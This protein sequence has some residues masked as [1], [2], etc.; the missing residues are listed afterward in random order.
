MRV[1]SA[2]EVRCSV[3]FRSVLFC[4]VRFCPVLFCCMHIEAV[5]C[6]RY[7]CLQCAVVCTHCQWYILHCQQPSVICGQCSDRSQCCQQNCSKGVAI[8]GSQIV[9]KKGTWP[10]NLSGRVVSGS[11]QMCTCRVKYGAEK[12]SLA[13]LK[14]EINSRSMCPAVQYQCH[15]LIYSVVF[16]CI[17]QINSKFTEHMEGVQICLLIGDYPLSGYISICLE[18]QVKIALH[19]ND[20]HHFCHGV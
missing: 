10:E 19:S 9:P 12:S 17:G 3:L 15:S 2:S 11:S 4:S 14:N 16:C 18:A 8:K 1:C 5:Q 7:H 13:A 6:A 20:H